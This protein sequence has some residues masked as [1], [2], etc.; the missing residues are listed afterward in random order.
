VTKQGIQPDA[1]MET[2]LRFV[3][4]NPHNGTTQQIV[5]LSLGIS[6]ASKRLDKS[7]FLIYKERT[8]LDEKLFSKLKVIGDI[9]NQIEEKKRK[10]VIKQLPP[11]YSTIHLLCSSLK[12]AEIVTAAKSKVIT[13]QISVRGAKEYIKQVRFP[14]ASSTDGEKGRWGHKQEHLYSIARPDDVPLSKEVIQSLETAL[15]RVCKDFGVTLQQP[16]DS[17]NTTLRK[18][19]RRTKEM[20]WRSILE[21]EITHQWFNKMPDMT[22]KQFNLKK[23]QELHSAPLRTFTGFIM[24][25]DG[26][27][28]IFWSKHGQAY[29]AKLQILSEWDEDAAQ[30]FNY[31]RRLEQVFERHTE[32]A[33]WSNVM[34]KHGGFV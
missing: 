9:L 21:K 31:R 24:N 32:L 33:I 27:R 7:V 3:E 19:E 2:F 18:Q 12:P 28:E 26:G 13:P 25:A 8:N 14:K 16:K 30:R 6:E 1:A 20:Y 5:L 34:M 22:K 11:S 17:S 4:E 15:R 29:V 10:D 23:V